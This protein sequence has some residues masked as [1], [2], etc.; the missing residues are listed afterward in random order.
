M[1]FAALA[2]VTALLFESVLTWVRGL[3]GPV[4][5]LAVGCVA[6]AG[7]V[8]SMLLSLARDRAVRRPST[9]APHGPYPPGPAPP[10]APPTH[11]PPYR[12]PRAPARRGRLPIVAV[13]VII[14]LLC[15]AGGV[16]VTPGVQRAV[17]WVQGM[18]C[19]QC[20]PGEDWLVGPVDGSAGALTVTVSEVEVNSRVIK[21]S[22]T[23]AN[24]GGE[25]LSLNAGFSHFTVAGQTFRYEG[26]GDFTIDA[27]PGGVAHGVFVYDGV[28]PRS[29]TEASLSF[30]TIFGFGP[31]SLTVTPIAL[32]APP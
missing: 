15:G 14:L 21:V 2:G 20:E 6:A 30:T 1:I 17:S 31:E 10:P 27:P 22:L 29:A 16:A 3:G 23:A 32:R 9:R 24:D 26:A 25:S 12:P 13:V 28:P 19:P 11:V 4:A 8:A 5:W 7:G 18:V